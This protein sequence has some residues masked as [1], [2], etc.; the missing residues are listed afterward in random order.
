MIKGSRQEAPGGM[1]QAT[2][3]LG[4]EMATWLTFGKDMVVAGLTVIHDTYVIECRRDKAG[5]LVTVTAILTGRDMIRE[6]ACGNTAIMTVGAVAAYAGV[7]IFGSGKG[8]GVMTHRTV[9]CCGQ[10]RRVFDRGD[11][12]RTIMAGNTVI[13]DAS[14]IE[15]SSSKA[16]RYMADT[17]ILRGWY[18]TGVFLGY[19][20][21]R[22]IR[23]AFI[24]VIHS[25]A[26]VE[27]EQGK[28]VADAMTQATIGRGVRMW[29]RRCFAQCTRGGC[30]TAIM[31]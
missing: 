20:T 10:V 17:A 28:A 23:M 21:C 22:T 25:T 26:M 24:A 29:G 18:V 31:A 4:C 27:Y 19:C 13:N 7:I 1:T 2:V 12:S 30:V 9:F 11:G 16:T 3:A 8:A 15:Y 14:V 6:F 5:G